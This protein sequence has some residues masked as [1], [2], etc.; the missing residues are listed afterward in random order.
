MQKCSYQ[1]TK[2]ESSKIHDDECYDHAHYSRL[3]KLAEGYGHKHRK[4]RKRQCVRHA[5]P[6]REN[7]HNR[8]KQSKK[9]DN[10]HSFAK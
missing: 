10:C 1:F 2:I 6:S 7:S 9:Q 4:R 8:V 3:F 5:K